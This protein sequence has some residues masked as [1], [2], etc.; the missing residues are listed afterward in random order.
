MQHVTRAEPIG[1]HPPPLHA[2]S[3]ERRAGA[4]AGGESRIIRPPR[5]DLHLRSSLCMISLTHIIRGFEM[6]QPELIRLHQQFTAD[7]A[8]AKLQLRDSYEHLLLSLRRII[9]SHGPTRAHHDWVSQDESI[10]SSPP[11][12]PAG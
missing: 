10:R 5:H 12:V 6:S 7:A 4:E 11:T 1:Q 9:E 8:G 2:E 3:G